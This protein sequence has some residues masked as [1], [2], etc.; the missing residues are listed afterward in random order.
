MIFKLDVYIVAMF[1]S[2]LYVWF[3]LNHAFFCWVMSL[4]HD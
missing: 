4:D 3:T 2:L 1:L